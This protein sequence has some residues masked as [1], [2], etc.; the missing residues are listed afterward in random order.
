[1]A[2]LIGTAGHVDHGKTSLIKA[3]TGIDADRLP[4]EKRRGLTIEVGF[5]HF[6]LPGVGLVSIVDVPGHEKFL[7]HMLAGAMGVGVALLCVAADSGVMPQTIEHLQILDLLPTSRVVVALTR[8]DVAD[9]EMLEIARLQV[10]D[11]LASTQFRGAPI[12]PVSAVTGLGLEQLKSELAA[13]ILS[14][15]PSAAR[16]WS[17]P[18]DRLMVHKGHG[19]VIA[20]SLAG[21]GVRPGD[22]VEIQPEGVHG[23][24]RAIQIH[25]QSI[26][27]GRPGFRVALNLSGVD[28]EEISRGSLAGQPGTVFKSDNFDCRLRWVAEIKH[29]SRI[30]ASLG[31]DEA[32]GRIFLNDHNPDLVQIRLERPIGIAKD[33]PVVVRTY[34]PA[35]VIG[36]GIVVTPCATKRRKNENLSSARVVDPSG[37]SMTELIGSAE[38]GLETE[39]VAR[40][41]GQSPGALAKRFEDHKASAALLSFAGLWMTPESFEKALQ[42]V[43]PA[44]KSLHTEFPSRALLPRDEVMK[45]A[46]SPWRGK[47][48][49]R[50]V[51]HLSTLGVIRSQGTQIAHA[52]HTPELSPRQRALLDQVLAAMS[53]QGLVSIGVGELA[54]QLRVPQPAIAEILRI[55][56]EAGELVFIGEG[57]TYPR[58]TL[59]SLIADVRTKL[60][61]K[62]FTPADFRDAFG[63][64]RKYAIPLLEYLDARRITSRV[65]DGRVV[66]Q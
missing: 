64:T 56:L 53:E 51:S 37:D 50:I 6:D 2:Y 15:A 61:G 25:G 45:A 54:T 46:G 58:S 13:A 24:V 7:H 35:T 36:G 55:G 59:E 23:R 43:L 39:E 1:M 60:G 29:G 22:S 40:R 48:L 18:I 62:T 11:A 49:D 19:T 33:V 5:A 65:Q 44:L 12:L 9:Q 52:E 10:E 57:L 66:N 14:L 63:A 16:P 41:L 26:E 21:G 32:I 8:A 27:E 3:L 20:G 31:A 17:L 30:R 28:K 47:P 34:S 38:W 42:L 4:E